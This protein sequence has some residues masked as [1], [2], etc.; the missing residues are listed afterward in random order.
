MTDITFP[1]PVIV[2]MPDRPERKVSTAF[3]ALEC[4]ESAW[5]Q[6]A[7]GAHWRRAMIACRDAL[8]GWRTGAEARRLFLK[9][10]SYAGVAY[11]GRRRSVNARPPISQSPL[12]TSAG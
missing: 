3:E 4:L 6:S 12:A 1:E 7:R 11:S 9:A 5:P 10:A 2:R 8:D